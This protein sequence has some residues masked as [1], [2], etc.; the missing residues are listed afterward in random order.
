MNTVNFVYH[1]AYTEIT[2]DELS[3]AHCG[4]IIVNRHNRPHLYSIF[5]VYRY[6][7]E[8]GVTSVSLD[9]IPELP[10]DIVEEKELANY[11]PH[12]AAG[13][14]NNRSQ[15]RWVLLTDSNGDIIS[16]INNPEIFFRTFGTMRSQIYNLSQRVDR[17]KRILDVMEDEVFITDELGFV[18]YINPRGEFIMGINAE[19]YLGT[20]ISEMVRK[21]ILPKSLTQL[22]IEKRERCVEL[23][24]LPT[25]IK[26]IC[27]AQPIYD[28]N[29]NMIQILSTS[30]NIDEITDKIEELSKELDSS[31]EQIKSLQEQVIGKNKYIFESPPMQQVQKTLMKVAPSDI[32]IL[33]EGESGVGKEVIADTIYKLSRRNE[34]PFVK[35]NCGLIPKDLMESELFGYEPGA[36]T[37]ALKN[38]KIGKIEVADGGTVFLDEIGEMELALQVK[39]LEFLQDRKITRVGGTKR[40]PVD[41][42]VIAA[43]N[44]DLAAMVDEGTFRQD[45]FYRLNVMP[46]Y[47]PPLRERPGDI[48]PMVFQFLNKYNQRYGYNRHID[49]DV[50]ERMAASPWP[51]NVLELLHFVERMVVASDNDYIDVAQYE[52]LLGGTDQDL[53][54]AGKAKVMCTELMPLKEAKKE[55]E[56]KLVKMAYEKFGSSYKAAEFLQVNQST[57]SRWL[58]KMKE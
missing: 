16:V 41:V 6:Y 19:D 28:D 15:A 13:N 17:Y 47:I 58:K 4:Y 35:I 12:Q 11:L 43:T 14:I 37:G 55:L 26:I 50:V 5:D 18:T 7:L 24:D 3:S 30:K 40:I 56:G 10:C 52:A 57:V 42:R 49:N 1:S 45:L 38:G 39:L 53:V 9:N 21:N 29:G 2:A 46:I 32:A 51:G 44:R 8:N 20:H 48:V 36:F 31:T 23:V 33:I 54:A 25:G 22:A 27:S 34:K